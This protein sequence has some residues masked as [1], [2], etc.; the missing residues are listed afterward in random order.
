MTFVFAIITIR[1]GFMG[2]LSLFGQRKVKETIEENISNNMQKQICQSNSHDFLLKTKSNQSEYQC[3]KCNISVTAFPCQRLNM[4]YLGSYIDGYSWLWKNEDMSWENVEQ[5]FITISN[6]ESW[7]YSVSVKG[8]S[9]VWKKSAPWRPDLPKGFFDEHKIELTQEQQNELSAA[10]S[11]LDF[12]KI[13]VLPSDFD[14]QIVPNMHG[15]TYFP[16]FRCTFQNGRGFECGKS[17]EGL[18]NVERL[19]LEFMGISLRDY[20]IYKKET[21]AIAKLLDE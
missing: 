20:E 17:V 8:L 21:K 2:L 7:S 19:L 15:S 11:Q 13:S 18:K 6:Y 1:G 5:F 12:S 3:R 4:T 10:L 9:L 16:K 14:V